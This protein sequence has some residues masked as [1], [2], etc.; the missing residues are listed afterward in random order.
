MIKKAEGGFLVC[1]V[2]ICFLIWMLS[3]SLIIPN[4]HSFYG[5]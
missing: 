2:M 5:F 1:V 4:I 3:T